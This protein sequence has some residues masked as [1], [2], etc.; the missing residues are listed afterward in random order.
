MAS[1]ALTPSRS[2]LLQFA[3]D[4]KKNEKA[5]KKLDGDDLALAE[6]VQLPGWKV[7]KRLVENTK[8][9]L[10]PNF[11]LEGNDDDFFK[12]YGMRSVIYDIVSDQLNA[13]VRRVENAEEIVAETRSEAL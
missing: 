2:S 10:K 7:L 9:N 6:L 1:E 12:S 11:D 3:R 8:N 5:D 13:L 4:I